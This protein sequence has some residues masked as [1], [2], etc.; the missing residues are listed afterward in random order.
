MKLPR[1]IVFFIHI[2]RM[3]LSGLQTKPILNYDTLEPLFE[4]ENERQITAEDILH[5]N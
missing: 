3:A 4:N 2:W 1:T 5:K